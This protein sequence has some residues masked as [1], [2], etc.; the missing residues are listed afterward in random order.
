MLSNANIEGFKLG[1]FMYNVF[2]GLA[3][4]IQYCDIACPS[5]NQDITCQEVDLKVFF[6]KIY[7]CKV[8]EAEYKRVKNLPKEEFEN[9]RVALK[10][11]VENN[12][13][14]YF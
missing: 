9:L 12:I 6:R 1:D 14:M 5:P 2:V 8:D 3:A 11:Y 7:R 4:E 13:D 10:D